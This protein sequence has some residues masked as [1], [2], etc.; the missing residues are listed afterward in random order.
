MGKQR[1]GSI[2]RGSG[3]SAATLLE[4]RFSGNADQAGDL[5]RRLD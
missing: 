3:N 2:R 4:F 1:I 5:R